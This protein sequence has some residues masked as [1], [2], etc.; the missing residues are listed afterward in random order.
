MDTYNIIS[1]DDSSAGSILKVPG[2]TGKGGCTAG[3]VNCGLR[4]TVDRIRLPAG[5]IGPADRTVVKGLID[6]VLDIGRGAVGVVPVNRVD[7]VA[8]GV[9]DPYIYAMQTIIWTLNQVQVDYE[10]AG[11]SGTIVIRP[12]SFMFF[13]VWVHL[14]SLPRTTSWKE[15]RPW[16]FPGMGSNR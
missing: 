8:G 14:W 9:D 13:R 7:I 16:P 11:C 2:G 3:G 10:A 5:V 6:P 1:V 4:K 12:V 15:K